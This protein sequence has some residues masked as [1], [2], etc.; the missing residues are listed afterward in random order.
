MNTIADIFKQKLYF[1]LVLCSLFIIC[2]ISIYFSNSYYSIPVTL[3]YYLLLFSAAQLI[4]IYIYIYF[5]YFCGLL[6]VIKSNL[7]YSKTSIVYIHLMG[8]YICYFL[9]KLLEI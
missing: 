7:N 3:F 9:V 6:I 4:S 2:Y 1:Y 8:C 5:Y